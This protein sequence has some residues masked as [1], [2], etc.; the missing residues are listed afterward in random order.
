MVEIKT[1]HKINEDIKH[2]KLKHKNSLMN[3]WSKKWA[4]V[5]EQKKVFDKYE[6]RLNGLL[7]LFHRGD[8]DSLREELKKYLSEDEKLNKYK[9]EL[10]GDD[11]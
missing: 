6:L 3:F 5:E 2:L 10:F 8:S 11:E 7:Y 9:K 4:S 1:T